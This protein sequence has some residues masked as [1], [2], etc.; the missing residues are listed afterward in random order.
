MFLKKIRLQ[1]FKCLSDI[2]LSF[3]KTTTQNRQWTL[4]LGENGTGKSNA[5]KAIALVTCGSNALGELLGDTDSWIRNGENS[6]L[7]E[8]IL[9]N[10]KGEIREISLKINRG[11]TL[12]NIFTNNQE[13]LNQLDSALNHADRNYFVVGY[14]A[15]RRLPSESFPNFEKS[16]SGVRSSN[17]RSLFNNT[18]SLNPLTSWIIDLDYRRGEEGMNVVREALDNFLPKTSFHSIDKQKRQVLFD[19]IDGVVP[20]DYLSD[21]YQN[22]VAWIGDLLFRITETFSDYSNPLQARGLLLIDEID[23]HLHPQWQRKLIEFISEKLPNFQ[24][25]ATTHSPLTAQ[26]ANEN[27]L[28]AFKRND[29]NI[30]HLLP[31]MGTPKTLLINQLL[32]TPVFG[33]STDES[34]EIEQDKKTYELLKAQPEK[35]KDDEKQLKSLENRLK[36]SLPKREMLIDS[37]K[38]L[39]LLSRIEANLNII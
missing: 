38:S 23:L 1:N 14:G 30:I 20:L 3:E 22:M 32:M 7:I 9:G 26:Q 6:C 12:S 36:N 4:I 16:S 10:K 17:V 31:F 27:E 24:V 21:G 37:E 29:E 8:A 28:Y 5:L 13:T 35:S 33:L 25:V 11:D 34:L 15:S 2:E 39:D 18:F 19:T